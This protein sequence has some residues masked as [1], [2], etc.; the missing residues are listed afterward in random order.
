MCLAKAG[1]SRAI[2]WAHLPLCLFVRI[3]PTCRCASGDVSIVTYMGR[4]RSAVRQTAPAKPFPL[5]V[6]NSAVILWFGARATVPGRWVCRV[7][8]LLRQRPSVHVPLLTVGD[9]SYSSLTQPPCSRAACV[10][11]VRTCLAALVLPA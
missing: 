10:R 2:C 5:C 8:Q 3:F 4:Q 6:W 11:S 1:Y 9:K 7:Y